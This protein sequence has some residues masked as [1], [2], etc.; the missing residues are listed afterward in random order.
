MTLFNSYIADFNHVTRKNFREKY[1][2]ERNFCDD[3]IFRNLRQCQLNK[4]ETKKNRWF[5]KLSNC[6]RKNIKQ[7]QRRKELKV[8]ILVLN[9]LL[10]IV[11]FWSTLQIEM[12]HR[13]LS[14]KCLEMSRE[15]SFKKEN[16]DS[17][18]IEITT[19]FQLHR[20]SMNSYIRR[21]CDVA[22]VDWFS[23]RATIA[24][25]QFKRFVRWSTIYH[26]KNEKS[27]FIFFN[28][29]RIDAFTNSK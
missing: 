1:V 23:N 18:F 24:N 29:W 27:R 7:F 17:S 6:K 11:K 3:D 25:S 15:T 26:A 13:I 19:L 12:F 2:N 8:L 10:N 16:I 9:R 22:F 4:N 21:R 28:F 14:L 5:V 20:Q